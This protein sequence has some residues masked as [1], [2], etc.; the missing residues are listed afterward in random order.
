MGGAHA[1]GYAGRYT[2]GRIGRITGLD[3]S[4]PLFHSVSP[5]DRLDTSDAKFVDVIHAAGYWVGYEGLL[6]HIDFYPNGGLAT[7]PGCRERES[8]DLS[9]SHFRAWIL[10]GESLDLL[11][12]EGGGQLVGMGCAD[13]QEFTSGE[14]CRNRQREVALLGEG[15]NK[16]LRGTFYLKT[17]SRAPF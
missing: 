15:I 1:A 6:G 16:T 8:L 3:P 2:D 9:C 10:F 11:K 7:Q 12:H 13:Y 14:C 5:E 4:G 17:N